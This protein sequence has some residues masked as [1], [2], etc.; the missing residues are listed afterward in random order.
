MNQPAPAPAGAKRR[1]GQPIN[2]KIE[3]VISEQRGSASP[4]NKTLSVVVGD[5]LE[6]MVR[7]DSLFSNSSVGTVPLHMDA[8]PDILA[9]GKIRVMF[10]LEYDLPQ[11]RDNADPT[12][13]NALEK[14]VNK[15]QIRERLTLILE[16]GKPIVATQSADPVTDRQVTVE[17]KATI[18][19]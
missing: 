11:R 4:V 8:S 12:N 5:G 7:S 14:G 2:V 6:G 15:T 13:P 10:G 16:N 18:L 1:A 9:D 17:V 3:A 19:K